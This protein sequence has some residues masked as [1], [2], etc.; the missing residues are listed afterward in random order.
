MN[1]NAVLSTV[2]VVGVVLVALILI[3]IFHISYPIS[4]VTSTRSG[5]LSV[6]GEGKVDVI[7]D[8]A[9]VNVG[10]NVDNRPSTQ[11][12]QQ[13]LDKVHNN[14]V[15]AML[16]LGIKKEDITTQNYSI[17]P[18]YQY[19]DNQNKPNGFTGSAS[20]SIKVRKIEQV[21]QVV[22]DATTAGA[23]EV[24]GTDFSVEN[25]DRY[26]EEARNKAIQNAKEQAQKLAITLGIHLG[27][28]TNIVE[29][30]D[31]PAPVPVFESAL[32]A[33][34]AGSGGPDIQPGSQ[35]ISTVVTLYFEKN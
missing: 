15:D 30:S 9:S 22:Q 3:N 10:I 24:Q 5:E 28:I 13:M 7:P 26:R 8:N 31:N 11:E 25:P 32:S 16:K 17:T 1:K 34:V 23:T 6:V 18:A 27:K 2:S 19:V 29:S 12:V 14:I 4:V 20:I 33:K 21:S 35:T